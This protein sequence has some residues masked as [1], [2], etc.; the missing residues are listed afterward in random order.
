MNNAPIVKSFNTQDDLRHEV[1][2]SGQRDPLT[3]IEFSRQVATSV[4]FLIVN[5]SQRA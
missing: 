1:R 2:G 4:T 5:V 3:H